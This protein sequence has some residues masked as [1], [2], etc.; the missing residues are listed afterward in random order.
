MNRTKDFKRG[1]TFSL[2]C[3]YKIDGIATSI[4]GLTIAS[5][6][7]DANNNL[8]ATL[9]KTNGTGTGEFILNPS[10]ADTSAWTIGDLYCDIKIT[11]AGVI[12]SSETF[13][14]PVISG[15]TQ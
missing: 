13:I 11:N 3:V 10:V 6:I 5:Q 9:N 12:V 1:N 2:A 4:S 14:I 8:V 7:R 15:V